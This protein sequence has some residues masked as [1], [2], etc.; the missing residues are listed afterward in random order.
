MDK[1]RDQLG[2]EPVTTYDHAIVETVEWVVTAT[3]G[4]DWRAVL[5][6]AADYLESKFNYEEED[7]F[8]STLEEPEHGRDDR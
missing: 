6:Q 5:P 3:R 8:I 2:Y 4:K 7:A 1:A